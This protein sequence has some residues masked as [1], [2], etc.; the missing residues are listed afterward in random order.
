MLYLIRYAEIGKE[1][2]PEKS[3]LE[4]DII[5]N[6]KLKIKNAKIKKDVGRI[7]LETEKDETETIKNIHGIASFSPCIKCPL[8]ELDSK[9]LALAEKMLR[10]KKSFGVRVKRVG[11]H[12]FTSQEKAGEIGARIKEKFP[13]LTV[14]LKMPDEMIFVEIRETDCYIFD[15]VIPGIDQSMKYEKQLISGP[16]F[17]VDDMLGKLAVRLRMLGFDTSFYGDSADSFLLRKSR[18]ED[19]ILLTRDLEI[20][21]VRG[22]N[23]FF[24]SSKKLK[25]Q[26]REV[27]EKYDLKISSENMFSRC[28]VCNEPLQ[29]LPKEKVKDKV[30][31]VV[32]KL[33]NEFAYCPKC[34]KYYW[35]GTHYEKI[36]E[37]LKDF[38]S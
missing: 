10:D 12:P 7:F 36:I 8:E 33:F 30:P 32:Y 18:E 6:L 11:M 23:A 28:S 31:P 16:K 17:I 22:A 20:T 4:R 13:H 15:K 37:D 14:D 21:K 19:R 27:I 2:H 1:P 26:I 3:K 5:E 9:V 29:D 34:D 25:D 38:I 35:K 24:V